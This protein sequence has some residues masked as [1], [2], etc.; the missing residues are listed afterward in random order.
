MLTTG[1]LAASTGVT[2]RTV[3]YYLKRGLLPEPDRDALGHRRY[4]A[5]SIIAL[6]RIRALSDA[7]VPLARIDDLLGAEP[8]EFA[9]IVT[10]IDEDLSAQIGE[11]ER[12]RRRIAG[13]APGDRLVLPD[14]A[15]R[16]LDRLRDIGVSDKL[17]QAERDICILLATLFPDDMPTWIREKRSAL[18]DPELQSLYL[19]VDRSSEWDPNDERLTDL[20]DSCVAYGDRGRRTPA[21]DAK[22]H[23]ITALLDRQLDDSPAPWRRLHQL[24][25]DRIRPA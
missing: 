22:R 2:V 12:R 20:A 15:L 7:G 10:Q 16:C 6:K 9:R 18:D 13:L 1:Q 5:R 25:A 24:C 17:V 19:E 8:V 11:L 14:G 4:D 3:L 23:S 21:A